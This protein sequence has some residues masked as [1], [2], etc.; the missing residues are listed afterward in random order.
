[1]LGGVE[2][3]TVSRG[4]GLGAAETGWRHLPLVITLALS[5]TGLRRPGDG[6]DLALA[7]A[8]DH[9]PKEWSLPS[10]LGQVRQ[11]YGVL[12]GLAPGRLPAPPQIRE[13]S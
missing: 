9:C 1:M 8:M 10:T 11:P 2:N 7:P 13:E 3:V 5:F 4:I 6:I 12:L